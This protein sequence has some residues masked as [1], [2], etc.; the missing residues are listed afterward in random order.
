MTCIAELD[1]YS[2]F[3]FFFSLKWFFLFCTFSFCAGCSR[4]GLN[5]TEG[6][7]RLENIET[8]YINKYIYIH[9]AQSRVYLLRFDVRGLQS[10]A[11]KPGRTES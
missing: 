9:D 8:I 7:T 4:Q 2:E 11:E 1:D 3:F 10:A 5:E 6:W